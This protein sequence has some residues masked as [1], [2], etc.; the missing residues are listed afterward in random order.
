MGRDPIKNSRNK[1]Y[2]G[3]MN[4][5]LSRHIIQCAMDAGVKEFCVSPGKRN[6]ALVYA[7]EHAKGLK[8]Y[9]WPEERSAAFFA[10]GR[11]RATK[12]PV[13]VVT[14]SGTAAA[15]L[16]PAAM[17]AYYTHQP[18]L[19]ITADRPRRLR[20]T[21]APQCAEQV[22]LFSYYARYMQDMSESETCNLH[23]WSFNGPAH[24]NICFEEPDAKTCEA[25]CQDQQI[26]HEAISKVVRKNYWS[27][28][29]FKEFLQEVRYP[30]VILGAIEREDRESVVEFLLKLRAPIYAEAPSG[31]REDVR[32][33]PWQVYSDQIWKRSSQHGYPIDGVLRIGSIPTCRIWRDLDEKNGAVKV[34][35]ITELPFSGLSW[36]EGIYAPIKDLLEAAQDLDFR[37]NYPCSDWMAAEREMLAKIKTLFYEEPRAE[38]SFFY[39]LSKRIS[40][41]ALVYLGNSLP[42]REWDLAATREPKELDVT[43][44]RGLCGIDGQIST[45]LGLSSTM[46]ENWGIIGDLTALFDLVGPWILQQLPDLDINLVIVNNGGG[47]IFSQM[48]A[49]SAFLNAHQ[50]SFEHMAKFWNWHYEKWETI[51]ETIDDVKGGRLIEIVPDCQATQRFLTKLKAL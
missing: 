31:L 33:S 3:I 19:L 4:N 22:G 7:L 9:Y 17:E 6:A 37:K 28:A 14:T 40:K 21:G 12:K 25:L 41:R 18:L 23:K 27:L 29:T 24:L 43:A 10:L 45:F 38:A 50:L 44:S 20:G 8:V 35:S 51:P 1:E 32:L 30:L 13:A 47:Q 26:Y 46:H 34:C 42:I 2:V 49:H 11:A 39:H 36:N 15:Q 16:L 48:F 5:Q